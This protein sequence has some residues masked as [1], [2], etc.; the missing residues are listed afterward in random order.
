MAGLKLINMEEIE[1]EQINW[2]WYPYIPFGKITIIQGDPGDGKTTMI[3]AVAAALTKGEKLPEANTIYPPMNV[4]YQTAEDGLGDTIKPRL[5]QANADCNR[6][7]VIDESHQE[8]TLNDSRIEKAIIETSARLFIVDPL[9]AYIGAKVDMYRANEVRPIFK[10]LASIAQKTN[11]AVVII[12][13]MSKSKSHKVNTQMLGSVDFSAATRSILSIG[14]IPNN[15]K[16]RAFIQT[17]NNLAPEGAAIA[18]ELNDG[19]RWLGHWDITEDELMRNYSSNDKD[20]L[21]K[22]KTLVTEM[23]SDGMKPC[24]EVKEHCSKNGIS[25]RT[26]DSAKSE[27]NVLSKR[28]GN[29][30][31][32]QL[33]NNATSQDI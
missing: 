11:C 20:A 15:P 17:K 19:F 2:L 31:Y 13:H 16:I 3:L 8:L 22:A 33:P 21:S 24:L 29:A 18:F 5:L 32:W 14:R 10:K 23:L 4:I 25:A 26:V 27:L 1:V 28:I 30:W 12:A 6:V 7:L 9:Q